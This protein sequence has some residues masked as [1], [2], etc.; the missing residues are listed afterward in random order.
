MR[1]VLQD[2]WRTVRIHLCSGKSGLGGKQAAQQRKDIRN[3]P[4]GNGCRL[5]G[6]NRETE[7]GYRCRISGAAPVCMEVGTDNRKCHVHDA[8]GRN[9]RVPVFQGSRGEQ[10]DSGKLYP[11]RRWLCRCE[12]PEQNID[13]RAWHAAALM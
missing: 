12:L 2:Q 7:A 5:R 10:R 6:R 11:K 8:A 13:D 1:K 9:A 3:V 4:A